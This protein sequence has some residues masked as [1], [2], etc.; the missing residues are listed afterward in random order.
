MKSKKTA[1]ILKKF[2]LFNLTT[3]SILGLFTI[4]Y[5]KAIQPNLVKKRAINHKI[6]TLKEPV[7]T[8][9]AGLARPQRKSGGLPSAGDSRNGPER[10]YEQ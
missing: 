4:F 2:L 10:F 5:L 1:S 6:K 7:G 8:G 9:G 3:F